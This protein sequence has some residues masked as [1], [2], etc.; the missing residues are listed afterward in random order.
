MRDAV[1][2]RQLQH[3]RV[4]HDEAALFRLQPVE[5]RQDH[6]VDGHRLARAGGA[7]DQ[8]VRHAGEVGDDRLAADVFSKAQGELVL[9]LDEIDRGQELAQVH[10][11]A[12]RVRQLDADHVAAGDDGDAGG[13]GGHR[14]GDVVRQAD[15][16]ARLGAGGRLQLVQGHDRAGAHGQNV[17]AHAKVLHGLLEVERVLLQLV[18][19][20]LL[21][22]GQRRLGEQFEGGQ[23]VVGIAD[24]GRLQ[25]A[26]GGNQHRALGQDRPRT[27]IRVGLDGGDGLEGVVLERVDEL[28]SG[29]RDGVR[30]RL[31]GLLGRLGLGAGLGAQQDRARGNGQRRHLRGRGGGLRGGLDR[32]G[33]RD[34][35][36]CQRCRG[37]GDGDRYGRR[38]DDLRKDRGRSRGFRLRDRPGG[39]RTGRADRGAGG[40]G[41]RHRA[42]R[43]R[44]GDR[45]GDL[46]R[47]FGRAEPAVQGRPIRDVR[48]VGRLGR[49]RRDEGRVHPEG[50]D[51]LR[52]D[53]GGGL[54]ARRLDRDRLERGLGRGLRRGLRD[55]DDGLRPA[56]GGAEEAHARRRH[57]RAAPARHL[58]D[59][60]LGAQPGGLGLLGGQLRRAL[61]GLIL[62]RLAGSL[63]L[64]RRGLGGGPGVEQGLGV[65]L[66]LALGLQRLAA[67]LHQ[68][69]VGRAGEAH[70]F[71][72]GRLR[73]AVG[74]A[75]IRGVG[76]GQGVRH[77]NRAGLR[78]DRRRAARRAHQ[79]AGAGGAGIDAALERH[80][81]RAV[82]GQGRGGPLEQ[83]LLPLLRPRLRGPSLRYPSLRYRG[84]LGGRGAAEHRAGRHQPARHAARVEAVRARN[85]QGRMRQRLRERPRRGRGRARDAPGEVGA[86]AHQ[87]MGD[88]ADRP[89]Q[90]VA[91]AARPRR[92][93]M[94][95]GRP[96]RCA[97][98][99]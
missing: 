55:L 42:R 5:Q 53:G 70:R 71:G 94:R 54:M 95:V 87:P 27:V 57:E 11:L 26:A 13:D 15:D 40:H 36:P 48:P 14:A 66:R 16:A 98:D 58:R 52:H 33:G 91:A 50:R 56:I 73:H 20:D 9:G 49:D 77:L 6:G 68:D 76:N 64:Q 31:G 97:H 24:E 1:V 60:L 43:G 99:L 37:E 3:L 4:D 44:G 96:S 63:R 61:G 41:V 47:G 65:G 18:R 2:D 80:L 75:R 12:H 35:L 19:I 51:L 29:L 7:G 90:A 39:Q 28:G 22:V 45:L 30:H 89:V 69:G 78:S 25:V 93:S 82:V 86:K 59:G 81:E 46:D 17:A 85:R 67:A 38:G 8:E 79:D 74:A 10:G 72:Q 83:P 88:A 34:R 23:F 21:A 32:S 84:L 92:I 62:R